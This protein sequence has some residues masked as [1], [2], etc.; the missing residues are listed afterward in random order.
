MY[1]RAY[2]KITMWRNR[3]YYRYEYIRVPSTLHTVCTGKILVQVYMNTVYTYPLK[4]PDGISKTY[5]CHSES[6]LRTFSS[7]AHTHYVISLLCRTING[8]TLKGKFIYWAQ[9]AVF[10]KELQNLHRMSLQV[11]FLFKHTST[12]KSSMQVSA[13]FIYPGGGGGTSTLRTYVQ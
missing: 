11:C 7:S 12:A 8:E 2:A 3:S 1:V 6:H 5:R 4:E 10:T 9:E 13:G